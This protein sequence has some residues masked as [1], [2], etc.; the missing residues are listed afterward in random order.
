MF[1]V[2]LSQS[3]KEQSANMS[4]YI[5]YGWRNNDLFSKSINKTFYKNLTASDREVAIK[6]LRN[7]IKS[8]GD[9]EFKNHIE[10]DEKT[11]QKFLFARKF[12]LEDSFETLKN[13]YWYRKRNPDIFRDLNLDSADV[14]K[15]LENG[16]PGVLKDKDRKGRCV[17]LL[18]ANNW[19]CSYSLL[20]I[21]RA[22]LVCLEQVT[23]DL[24][25]QAN[26]V[27]VIVD[28]T[29]FSYKQTSHLKPSILRLMIEGLQ[30]CF[31]VRFKGIHFIGQPWYVDA[32]LTVIKPFL[33]EEIKEHIFRH[34]N[35][36]STLHE[37][38]HRDVLPAELGGEQPSYNPR[39]FLDSL[40]TKTLS[41]KST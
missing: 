22:M 14:R 20:S 9:I 41:E 12:I 15:A 26:G 7:V 35:N 21:Y 24:H 19:D 31:P 3:A 16:L 1:S 18:T 10:Q 11:L 37:L 33:K 25:N 28:W 6:A 4:E 29:E 2:I 30:D 38:V 34:G 39:S 40:D 32:A 13:F 27:V 17:L 8:C 5:D 23:N 36:L